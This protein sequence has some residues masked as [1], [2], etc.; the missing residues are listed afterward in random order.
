[1]NKIINHLK[2]NWIKYGFETFVITIGILGAFTLNNWNSNRIDRLKERDYIE[3]L[4]QEINGDIIH[5]KELKERFETKRNRLYRI[6]QIWR[7]SSSTISDS[8][9]YISDFFQAGN[10]STVYKEPIIWTELIQNGDLKLIKDKDLTN[11]MITYHSQVKMYSNN[12]ILHP[13]KMTMLAREKQF[14]PFLYEMPDS[15]SRSM[16]MKNIPRNDVYKRIWNA[17]EEYLELYLIIAK[18]SNSQVLLLQEIIQS[19][20][21]L[22]KQLESK[23]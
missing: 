7:S 3:R 8:I 23:I 5:Y 15:Y 22:E 20:Q 13:V 4:S 21:N 16:E 12:F 11:A 19:G 14:V 6:T 17:R 1:M 10:I 9:Q 18:S 2:E